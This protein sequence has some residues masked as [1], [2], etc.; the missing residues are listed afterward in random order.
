M[1]TNNKIR[2]F[3]FRKKQKKQVKESDFCDEKTSG[4]IKQYSKKI[5]DHILGM[6]QSTG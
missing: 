2:Q 6:L 1:L 4:K 5:F 3:S